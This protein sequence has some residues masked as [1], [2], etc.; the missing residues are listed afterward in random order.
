MSREI[1][2]EIGSGPAGLAGSPCR[3]IE[4]LVAEVVRP[5]Q[6]APVFL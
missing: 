2:P 5:K 4:E 1:E 3:N 6:V